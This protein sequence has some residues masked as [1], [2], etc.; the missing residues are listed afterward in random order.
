MICA[1]PAEAVSPVQYQT[2]GDHHHA[3]ASIYL[4]LDELEMLSFIVLLVEQ[5]SI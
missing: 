1:A 5:S 4:L 3:R 2:A